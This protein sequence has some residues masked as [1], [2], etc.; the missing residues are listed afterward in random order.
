MIV[1]SMSTIGF[2]LTGLIADTKYDFKN[3]ILDAI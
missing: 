2:M 1:L 3:A